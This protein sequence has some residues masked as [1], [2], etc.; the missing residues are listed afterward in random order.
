MDSKDT[1][2]DIVMYE[3]NRKINI[4]I[5]SVLI[6]FVYYMTTIAKHEVVY[7]SFISL[8][9]WYILWK[10]YSSYYYKTLYNNDY[11]I[12]PKKIDEK[13]SYHEIRTDNLTEDLYDDEII[14]E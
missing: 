14:S 1:L 7:C 6:S 12:I 4:N 5:L 2:P 3:K 8:L 10:N 13:Q 11:L 9:V